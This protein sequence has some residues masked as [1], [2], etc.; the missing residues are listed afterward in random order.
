LNLP[1]N[2][3]IRS[4]HN[5]NFHCS[6]KLKLSFFIFRPIFGT[7]FVHHYIDSCLPVLSEVAMADGMT[8]D[9]LV[10]LARS[11]LCCVYYEQ[12]TLELLSH[13]NPSPTIE[14]H[15]LATPCKSGDIDWFI[16]H[17][18]HD[19]PRAKFQ[20][21]QEEANAF[22]RLRGRWPVLWLDKVCI[23]QANIRQSLKC[24][25]VYLMACNSMLVLGGTTYIDRLWCVW[26]LYTLFAVSERDPKLIVRDFSWGATTLT[27]RLATFT[28][29]EHANC[30][31]PN[32][33]AKLLQAIR[34]AP[35]GETSF[36]KVI[37]SLADTVGKQSA[38]YS[39]KSSMLLAIRK[40][41]SVRVSRSQ[42]AERDGNG[43]AGSNGP[44]SS[45]T[46]RTS[47][48]KDSPRHSL[49]DRGNLTGG[50]TLPPIVGT[51]V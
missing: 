49:S 25:P 31:D 21:L 37:R 12:V 29:G 5:Q 27:E 11:T 40:S 39:S 35:G 6:L 51:P 20:C 26:E 14:T 28:L 48:E 3:K 34:A 2:G 32:E 46:S 22:K 8:A 13:D 23:D 1:I 38:D 36:N 44:R 45:N 7:R 50:A 16:S 9:A 19:D 17:S 42:S 4:I 30:Y 47:K 18:W 33:K 41:V 10:T 15:Q 24:L 43:S